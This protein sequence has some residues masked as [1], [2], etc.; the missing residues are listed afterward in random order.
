[1]TPGSPPADV[2]PAA[3]VLAL[4]E[5]RPRQAL[6]VRLEAAPDVPL[7]AQAAP[8]ADLARAGTPEALAAICVVDESGAAVLGPDTIGHLLAPEWRALQRELWPALHRICPTYGRCNER[9]WIDT[10]KIGF[11]ANRAIEQQM[12]WC[13]DVVRLSKVMLVPRPDRFFG[14]PACEVLDGHLM[15]FAALRELLLPN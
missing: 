3:L 11:R 2:E 10:L 7:W 15:M 12:R 5:W 4:S 6:T 9:S 14:R 1:M 8:G 13:F